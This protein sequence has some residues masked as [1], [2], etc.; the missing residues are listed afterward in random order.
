[1]SNI[2]NYDGDPAVNGNIQSAEIM[3]TSRFHTPD[4]AYF[5]IVAYCV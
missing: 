4:V 2:R 1:M 3:L 5:D